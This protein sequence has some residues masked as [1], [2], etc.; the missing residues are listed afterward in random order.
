MLESDSI[1]ISNTLAASTQPAS[2]CGYDTTATEATCTVTH[3]SLFEG[4]ML[5]VEHSEVL[6]RQTIDNYDWVFGVIIALVII[7]FLYVR[8]YR[9]PLTE[10]I[11]AAFDSRVR[12]RIARENNLSHKS[13]RIPMAATY[14]G[15]IA[16][17]CFYAI[18]QYVHYEVMLDAALFGIILLVI[19]VVHGVQ[20]LLIRLFGSSFQC[21]EGTE[22][23][24]MNNYIFRILTS[25]VIIPLLLFLFFVESKPEIFLFIILGVYAVLF[26]I[27]IVRGAQIILTISNSSKFYL[28][29]YLCTL[30]IA[31]ILVLFKEIT[32]YILEC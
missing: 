6:V 22:E 8:N 15:V 4:H 27:R 24:I 21:Q 28:F 29:Y 12:E 9:L 16:L 10:L 19:V 23:Y 5:Q 26:L 7:C 14:T 20:N 32:S 3:K 1:L 25:V 30:E 18:T 2:P 11:K 17:T 13:S 31:P